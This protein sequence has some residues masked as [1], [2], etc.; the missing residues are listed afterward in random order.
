MNFK[1]GDILS[2]AHYSTLHPIAV[3][4][5]VVKEDILQL[6]NTTN[7]V[8][9]NP[10]IDDPIVLIGKLNKNICICEGIISEI[11]KLNKMIAVRCEEIRFVSDKRQM[12]RVATSLYSLVNSKETEKTIVAL[13]KNIS[14]EGIGFI[15]KEEF[16]PSIEVEIEIYLKNSILPLKL[17]LNRKLRHSQNFEYGSTIIQDDNSKSELTAIF[18]NLVNEHE[19]VMQDS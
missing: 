8:A 7:F 16:E 3:A 6:K 14:P 9:L 11:D 19:K 2:L 5:E 13:V 10:S 17:K 18:N 15:S 12:F 4:I 1:I